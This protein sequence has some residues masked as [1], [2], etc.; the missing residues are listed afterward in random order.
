MIVYDSTRKLINL[1]QELY[2]GGEGAIHPLPG[3][4][5]LVAKIYVP[6]PPKGYDDKLA[7]M[8][9]NPPAD[10]SHT[11][12]HASIAWPID[13]LY[14]STGKFAGYT[15]PYIRNT[16]PLLVVFNPRSRARTL[17]GFDWRYLHRAARN[18]ASA[19]TA[20]HACGYVVGDINGT[21]FL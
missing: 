14:T 12:G 10:P 2:R 1:G 19:I 6:A 4:G 3:Q 18:L 16:V 5:H 7:W 13:L 20:L 17:P 15:M 11:P 8:K 21:V 9:A